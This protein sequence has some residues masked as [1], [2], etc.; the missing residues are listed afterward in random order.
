MPQTI[1]A[2]TQVP[3]TSKK[4]NVPEPPTSS[5]AKVAESDNSD[6]A[7]SD[8]DSDLEP[9]ELVPTYLKIK[10]RIFELDP[11][12]LET[13][14]SKSKASKSRSLEPKPAPRASAAVRKLLSQLQKLESDTLFDHD[15]AQALWPNKRNQIA[16]EK[17]AK[18][19]PEFFGA[20]YLSNDPHQDESSSEIRPSV[21]PPEK[22]PKIDD[23]LSDDG[24]LGD[25]FAA[26][27]DE[28]LAA[29]AETNESPDRVTLR[30]F[31]KQIGLP[32]RRI[33]E[34]AVRARFVFIRAF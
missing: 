24:M 26:I 27:P 30:D 14:P 18:W 21:D 4:A 19:K 11:D 23:E 17:A 1:D 6:A 10:G 16:Q 25:M 8:L 32:P 29:S 33:L 15:E 22:A 20:S 28:P 7:I 5:M 2:D 31:G 12:V 3:D 13:K 34:E 9:D